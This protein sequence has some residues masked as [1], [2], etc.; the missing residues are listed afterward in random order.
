MVVQYQLETHR[1]V[2]P[3]YLLSKR[4]TCLSWIHIICTQLFYELLEQ[5]FCFL[6]IFLEVKFFLTC[7]VLVVSGNAAIDLM[8]YCLFYDVNIL[9]LI[10]LPGL[11][12]Q[13]QAL[14]AL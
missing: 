9:L 2:P 5:L 4:I 11:R 3:N 12:I 13:E 14:H 7:P 6:L 8:S 10:M 1:H